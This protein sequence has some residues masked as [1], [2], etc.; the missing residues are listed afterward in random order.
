VSSRSDVLLWAQRVL[1]TAKTATPH[2]LLDM[3]ADAT[4]EVAQEA[5]HK[6]A[7][8]AHPDLH[9]NHLSADELETVTAAYAACAAAYQTFRS[10]VQSTSRQRPVRTT[11]GGTAIPATP[12]GTTAAGNV[13]QSMTSRALVHYRKAEL[14]LRRGDLSGAVLQ[15]KMAIAADPHSAFLRSALVEVETEVRKGS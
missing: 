7:R 1:G 13:A 2:Q 14:A 11:S 9:R 6:I 12:S 8:I 4:A 5:F 3:P 10:N 15:L